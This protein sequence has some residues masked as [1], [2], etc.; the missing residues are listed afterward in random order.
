MALRES[1]ARRNYIA[2][3]SRGSHVAHLLLDCRGRL[4][5]RG[6]ISPNSLLGSF[7][8]K[9]VGASPRKGRN[10]DLKGAD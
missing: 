10:D 1:V 5:V 9:I 4:G 8:S 6:I 3:R 2:D 7:I